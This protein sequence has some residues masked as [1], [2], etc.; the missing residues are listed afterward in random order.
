MDLV[1]DFF[2]AP[3]YAQDAAPGGGLTPLI[4]MV[5][6]IVVFY[7]MI[8]RPQ[9]KKQKEHREMVAALAVGDEV[10]TAGGILGKVSRVAEQFVDVV[11]AENVTITIQ[12]H[13]IGGVMPKGTIKNT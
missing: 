5:G 7:F 6:L 1:L 13:T 8:I 2:I 3:A 4:M 10:V 11:I 9:N 12:R